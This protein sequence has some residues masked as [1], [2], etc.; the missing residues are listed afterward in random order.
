MMETSAL[1]TELYEQGGIHDNLQFC[2][3]SAST[4]WAG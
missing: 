1:C 4:Y 3:D 2:N